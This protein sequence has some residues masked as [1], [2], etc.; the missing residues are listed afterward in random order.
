MPEYTRTL[1]K[2]LIPGGIGEMVAIAMPMAASFACDTVMM[3]TDRM[4]LSRLG[5]EFMNSAMTGGLTSFLALSF[6]FGITGYVSAVVAQYFGAGRKDLC[7]LVVTQGLLLSVVAY[8]LILWSRPLFHGFFLFMDLPSEQIEPT[9][10]YFDILVLGSVVVLFRSCLSS[11]FSGIGQTKVVMIAAL[12]AMVSNMGVSFILVFGK[13]G[14]SALGI[15]GAAI[16]SIVGSFCGVAV[17]LARYFRKDIQQMFVIRRSF[18]VNAQ[19]AGKLLRFGYPTGLEIFFSVLAFDTMVMMFH[20][21]GL[22]AATAASIMFNWDMVAF[23]PLLGVE[24]GVT[25]LVGRYMGAGQPETAHRAAMS[26]IKFGFG[27]SLVIFILFVGFPE[28]LVNAFS[29]GGDDL[30]FQQA[31]PMAVRMLRFASAYVAILAFFIAIIGALRGAGDTLWAMVYSV[32]LHWILTLVAAGMLRIA[33]VSVVTA[34]GA[35]IMT[36]IILASGVIIRY[37]Q[38]AWKS[39]RIVEPVL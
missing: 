30:I 34:W 3:F 11:F 2:K 33:G 16:G 17:L 23:I 10:T 28:L 20:S 36:F 29:P 5:P 27:Y 24:V 19:V 6:F 18:V 14:F 13:F 22:V 37:R 35:V 8:P 15:K 39:I 9:R 32:V 1:R 12:V 4:F 26:G 31:S 7:P 21:S 38:G 25:S